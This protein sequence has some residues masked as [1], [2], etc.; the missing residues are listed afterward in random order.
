MLYYYYYPPGI[1]EREYL[2]WGLSLSGAMPL[3]V[4]LYAMEKERDYYG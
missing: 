1:D 4:N 3:L 2:G